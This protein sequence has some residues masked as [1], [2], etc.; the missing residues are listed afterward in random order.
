MSAKLINIA[1]DLE[2]LSTREDAAI[3]QIG[4]CI[5]VFDRQYIP[6]D[7]QESS[8][9]FEA[10]IAYEQCITSDFHQDTQTMEWWEK[11]DPSTRSI[12][13]SGQDSYIDAFDSFSF[14]IASLKSNGADVAIWGNG[15]DFDNR[16]LSYSLDSLG[17]HRVWNYQNNRDLRTL[18]ALFPLASSP[19]G[20]VELI[21]GVDERKHTA[22]G[23]AR[24]E[25][26]LIDITRSAYG[27]AAL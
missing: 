12:V 8:Y 11:Q 17:Y 13:F 24:Y 15:S 6:V 4:A 5:P 19:L 16:L 2:T 22:L 18:K 10:T 3:I 21:T 26:R 1:L 27:I 23:D 25:A 14:W 20:K 7:M 9:E